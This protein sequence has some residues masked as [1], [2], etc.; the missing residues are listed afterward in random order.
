M[1][2]VNSRVQR[3]LTLIPILRQHPGIPLAQLERL[4]GYPREEILHELST[5]LLM[6]GVPPYLPHDFLSVEIEDD[7]VTLHFANH[8]SRPVSLDTLEAVALRL[9]LAR[10]APQGSRSA[11]LAAGLL[12]KVEG[13]MGHHQRE[14]VKFLQA[15][16]SLGDDPTEGH[17]HLALITHAVEVH[18]LLEIE[19]RRP[20]RSAASERRFAPLALREIG[21]H[22]YVLARDQRRASLRTYRVDRIRSVAL[23]TTT[24]VPPSAQELQ[25]LESEWPNAMRPVGERARLRFA[26]WSARWIEEQAPAQEIQRHSDHVIWSPVLHSGEALLRFLC[27][28]G[29]RFSVLAPAHLAARWVQMVRGVPILE[30]I[31]EFGGS[32]SPESATPSGARG[33]GGVDPKGLARFNDGLP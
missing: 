1:S 18:R 15:R 8:F 28:P 3:C 25:A 13:A 33:V 11:R 23:L 10:V 32:E 29:I 9:A 14:Q 6:C 20:G 24:F 21:G 7:R 17:R 12:E 19:Y 2:D 26:G 22:W 4:T 5:S 27:H 16:L 31:E 30:D